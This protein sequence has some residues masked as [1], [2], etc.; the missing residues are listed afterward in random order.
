MSPAANRGPKE[1]CPTIGDNVYIGP[2]AKLFGRISIGDNAAIGANAVVTGDM[3]DSAVAV[4]VPA[5]AVS[6]SGSSGY[7]NNTDYDTRGE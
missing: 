4:G 1:G 2:G 3:P 6:S 7:V 5:K